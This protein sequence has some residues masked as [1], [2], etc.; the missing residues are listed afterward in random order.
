MCS[1]RLPTQLHGRH[2]HS[3]SSQKHAKFLR[4]SRSKAGTAVALK[5]YV[6]R[7]QRPGQPLR[8][9][10]GAPALP[11][12]S[13]LAAGRVARHSLPRH[14]FL[15]SQP[16]ASSPRCNA[17]MIC[18]VISVY[19][20]TSS[21]KRGAGSEELEAGSGKLEAQSV[22]LGVGAAG[23]SSGRRRRR[24]AYAAVTSTPYRKM[25]AEIYT[26]TRN[27]TTAAIDP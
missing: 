16:P 6:G 8:C 12:I 4:F 11:S 9:S 13:C 5:E 10:A 23:I 20:A 21:W 24:R 7:R 22:V 17:A 3:Q 2:Y 14:I 15:S 25:T 18:S 26:Q 19:S 27:T 1:D